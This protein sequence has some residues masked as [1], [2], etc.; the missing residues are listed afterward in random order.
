MRCVTIKQLDCDTHCDPR[1][2]TVT[3]YGLRVVLAGTMIDEAECPT[4]DCVKLVKMGLADPADDECRAAVNMT[5]EQ[6]A[7]AQLA[8]RKL[9]PMAPES[10]EDDEDEDW[11]EEFA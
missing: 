7:K 3:P 11:E 5:P 1:L 4:A 10:E 8:Q 9:T 2:V 6:I